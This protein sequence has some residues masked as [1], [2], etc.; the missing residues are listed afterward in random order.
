M[1]TINVKTWKQILDEAKQELENYPTADRIAVPVFVNNWD[2]THH[3]FGDEVPRSKWCIIFNNKLSPIF[4]FFEG[5]D[6]TEIINSPSLAIQYD[7]VIQSYYHTKHVI[8]TIVE[9]H[10][11]ND[12]D[13]KKNYC[14]EF[15][16]FIQVDNLKVFVS[17]Y[18]ALT[19]NFDKNHG[20]CFVFEKTYWGSLKKHIIQ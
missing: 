1:K 20:V 4:T 5:H 10:C 8:G 11:N 19:L 6:S 16:E 17:G 18:V 15:I 14:N 13:I 3:L 2:Y 7:M 12:K 9:D